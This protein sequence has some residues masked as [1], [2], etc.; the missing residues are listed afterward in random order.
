MPAR[1]YH[2]KGCGDALVIPLPDALL[3]SDPGLDVTMTE[4]L[5]VLACRVT[6]SRAP[7]CQQCCRL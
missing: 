6:A 4:A 2:Q 7:L 5:F 1:C 3:E